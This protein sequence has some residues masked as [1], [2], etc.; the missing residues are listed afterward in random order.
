MVQWPTTRSPCLKAV[1]DSLLSQ[2][3]W[4]IYIKNCILWKDKGADRIWRIWYFEQVENQIKAL[5]TQCLTYHFQ[6]HSDFY[7]YHISRNWKQILRINNMYNSN[8]NACQ[9]IT[10]LYNGLCFL[11]N[12]AGF[13]LPKLSWVSCVLLLLQCWKRWSYKPVLVVCCWEHDC[14]WRRLI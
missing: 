9:Y 14:A 7:I 11:L 6:C 3:L 4:F 8:F 10:Q 1:A 2:C 12:A 5:F 13:V